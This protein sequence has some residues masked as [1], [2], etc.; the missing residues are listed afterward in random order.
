MAEAM[1]RLRRAEAASSTDTDAA[2]STRWWDSRSTE[3][4]FTPEHPAPPTP[5]PSRGEY[6]IENQL[7]PLFPC[8][9]S[10]CARPFSTDLQ[11][12]NHLVAHHGHPD[13]QV[14]QANT[15]SE[16][17]SSAARSGCPGCRFQGPDAALVRHILSAN[18]LSQAQREQFFLRLF[19]Q[20]RDKP[21]GNVDSPRAEEEFKC[22]RCAFT[23]RHQQNLRRHRQS[24]TACNES[25]NSP[26]PA[27]SEPETSQP[28][29]QLRCY[30]C[31]FQPAASTR[32]LDRVKVLRRHVSS[33]AKLACARFRRRSSD[34]CPHCGFL[35]ASKDGME[36][37]QASEFGCSTQQWQ[38][39]PLAT[40]CSKCPFVG[41]SFAQLKVHMSL[42]G[43]HGQTPAVKPRLR[44]Q[45]VTLLPA[46]PGKQTCP[47]CA[48][49]LSGDK[50]KLQR[51]LDAVHAPG[52]VPR[53]AKN[54]C[55][56]CGKKVKDAAQ[57]RRHRFRDHGDRSQ[58]HACQ[59]CDYASTEL[60]Q[61][62]RHQ[63]RVHSESESQSDRQPSPAETKPGK[64]SCLRCGFRAESGGAF[65]AHQLGSAECQAQLAVSHARELVGEAG[66]VR[67]CPFCPFTAKKRGAAGMLSHAFTPR[68]PYDCVGYAR[69]SQVRQLPLSMA[70]LDIAQFVP[71]FFFA[72]F[73]SDVALNGAA[74]FL[75]R[76]EADWKV[77][78]WARS[79]HLDFPVVLADV[80]CLCGC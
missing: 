15:R 58:L 69:L 60:A 1:I 34:R 16:A 72:V 46:K 35:A 39:R 49:T 68:R 5:A 32:A 40:K 6:V 55:E 53:P 42:P 25:Q 41:A 13:S 64:L 51:H 73:D 9:L 80:R 27:T 70:A 66:D 57:L 18:C 47:L 10:D 44:P 43:I 28:E 56:E 2:E 52:K 50:A 38:K 30:D 74:L 8:T 19:A 79:R 3:L 21:S 75:L 24:K 31:G 61:L 33:K 54:R 11:R 22:P 14:D 20:V 78:M 62:R 67:R 23:T 37:H 63:A 59:A 29:D 45:L 71:K 48:K 26:P 65:E 12:R 36:K 76:F 77:G 17:K 7:R 4:E